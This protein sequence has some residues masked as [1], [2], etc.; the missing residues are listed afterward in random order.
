MISMIIKKNKDFSM[1][2]S[3]LVFPFILKFNTGCNG[4]IPLLVK[5]SINKWEVYPMKTNNANSLW[6]IAKR[7]YK[8]SGVN[9][10]CSMPRW[11][12]MYFVM[13]LNG[14]CFDIFEFG[15]SISGRIED[16]QIIIIDKIE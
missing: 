15:W 13:N 1:M 14:F 2:P 9:S 5:E 12:N 10:E 6:I 4:F 3:V 8:K 11:F 7:R 16:I